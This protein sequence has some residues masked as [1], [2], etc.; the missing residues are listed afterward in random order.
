MMSVLLE[1]DVQAWGSTDTLGKHMAHHSSA[2]RKPY[3]TK[4]N[5]S[6]VMGGEE[7]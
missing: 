6:Y 2:A 4:S 7:L 3:D 1:K 5:K